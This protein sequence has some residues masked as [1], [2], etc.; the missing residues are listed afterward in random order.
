MCTCVRIVKGW[1]RERGRKFEHFIWFVTAD[2][3]VRG[4]GK[5]KGMKWED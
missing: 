1:R 4:A 5:L 3:Q 2:R